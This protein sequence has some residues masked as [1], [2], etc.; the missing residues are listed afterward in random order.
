MYISI[1]T[2]LYICTYMYTFIY[3][4]YLYVYIYLCMYIY[5]YVYLY[6][7]LYLFICDKRLL[8]WR[9]QIR[10]VYIFASISVSASAF[11][12]VFITV[13]IYLYL[14]LYL[15]FCLCL[16]FCVSRS[17]CASNTHPPFSPLHTSINHQSSPFSFLSLSSLFS[18]CFVLLLLCFRSR[19]SSIFFHTNAR[20]DL[21]MWFCPNQQIQGTIFEACAPSVSSTPLLG[22]RLLKKD[23]FIQKYRVGDLCVCVGGWKRKCEWEVVCASVRMYTYMY[24]NLQHIYI[25]I[26]I[27]THIYGSVKERMRVNEFICVHMYVFICVCVCTTYVY[28]YIYMCVCV[29]VCNLES[30]SERA[31]VRVYVCIHIC[32]HVC[33]TR[34]H[35]L[36]LLLLLRKK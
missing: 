12:F 31:C 28:I 2:Y 33:N 32:M 7:Y 6:I 34:I 22:A 1:Y 10:R 24:V 8:S 35:W 21:L 3:I 16:C 29:W 30:T 14:Y 17:T 4:M 18:C 13:C 26:R 11:F 23:T 19:E 36:M 20:H 15:Y 27:Y 5:I 25:Y 9:E